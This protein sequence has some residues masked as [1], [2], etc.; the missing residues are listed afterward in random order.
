MSQIHL[1]ILLNQILRRHQPARERNF[2]I[3][4]W[5]G[6]LSQMKARFVAGVARSDSQHPR[7]AMGVVWPQKG[8]VTSSGP[9]NDVS[10]GHS[11]IADLGQMANWLFLFHCTRI[12]IHYLYTSLSLIST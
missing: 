7:L 12:P 9:L 6:S 10:P 1:K 4:S 5:L 11:V 3:A 8:P 2:R